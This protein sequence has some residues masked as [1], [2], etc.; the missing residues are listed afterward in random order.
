MLG[1]I[2]VVLA[3]LDLLEGL[4]H[5]APDLVHL[6]LGLLPGLLDVQPGP[7]RG[8]V[9]AVQLVQHSQQPDLRLVDSE[10]VIQVLLDLQRELQALLRSVQLVLQV[11]H[12]PYSGEATRYAQLAA[13]LLEQLLRLLE[14]VC[15][16]SLLLVDLVDA[17]AEAQEVGLGCAVV[18]LPDYLR[19]AVQGLQALVVAAQ[20]EEDGAVLCDKLAHLQLSA[21]VGLGRLA[22]GSLHL[23]GN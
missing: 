2:G 21:V 10:L 4:A 15:S 14:L 20:Q 17:G 13:L 3:V 9:G 6:T 19:A 7:A 5:V 1:R 23:R 16:L 11:G 22:R 18:V 12:V 8:V